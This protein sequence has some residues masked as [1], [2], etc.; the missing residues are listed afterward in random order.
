ME[1]YNLKGM[2]EPG[3]LDEVVGEIKWSG[4][5][6]PTE[7]SLLR[8]RKLLLTG[9][10]LCTFTLGAF[11][12][13]AAVDLEEKFNFPYALDSIAALI[14]ILTFMPKIE[15]QGLKVAR[16]AGLLGAALG[17]TYFYYFFGGRN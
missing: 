5:I 13:A 7:D 4:E 3:S 14:S 1:E 8:N 16:Y 2:Y 9:F 15:D 12:A 11:P 10:A 17:M 6:A